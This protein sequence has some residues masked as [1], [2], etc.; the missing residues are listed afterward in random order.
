MKRE[1][2]R[3]QEEKRKKLM[4]TVP[5]VI[6]LLALYRVIFGFSAQDGEQSGSLSIRISQEAVE[7]FNLL[8][9]RKWSVSFREDLAAYFEHPIRKLAHFGEY[10]C[11]GVLVY[12]VLAPWMERGKKLYLAAVAWVFLSAACDEIHQLFVPGRWGS[13]A[14]VLLDTCGG[15][16]GLLV[17]VLLSRL[18]ERRRGGKGKGG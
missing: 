2:T 14:D 1:R 12:L 6:L 15:A 5:A 3:Q 4:A 13:P 18:R 17:C 9:G 8:A 7:F 11:M 10:A 16:F